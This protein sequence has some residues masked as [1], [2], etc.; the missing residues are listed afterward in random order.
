MTAPVFRPPISSSN[1][2]RPSTD[3]TEGSSG[4]DGA[5]VYHHGTELLAARNL[6][7]GTSGSQ[8]FA[9]AATK[10]AYLI[11]AEHEPVIK[12]DKPPEGPEY[13]KHR[14][15]GDR[16]LHVLH[17]SGSAISPLLSRLTRLSRSVDARRPPRSSVG[18]PSNL[19]PTGELSGHRIVRSMAQICSA[20]KME[21]LGDDCE[22]GDDGRNAWLICL[23][24]VGVGRFA[25]VEPRARLLLHFGEQHCCCECKIKPRQIDRGPPPSAVVV[26]ISPLDRG[27]GCLEQRLP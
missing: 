23:L 24:P 12:Q 1:R 11:T 3:T 25:H 10:S 2:W 17:D 19:Y 9:P 20:P 16:L 15:S 6:D 8:T 21:P 26:I 5:T 7:G 27:H 14:G 4:G 18:T 22:R 13:A